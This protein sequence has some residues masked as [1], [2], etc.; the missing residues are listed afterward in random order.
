MNH[1]IIYGFKCI[2]YEDFLYKYLIDYIFKFS[3]ILNDKWGKGKGKA[4]L[5][6]SRGG[7]YGCETSRLSHFLDNQ[8]THGGE[9]VSL[10][11]RPS[12]TP[13][14]IPGTHFCQRLSRC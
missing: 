1:D 7:P 4:I 10:M 3:A 13:R 14:K 12:F 6:R 8:L 2:Y 9:V 5:I 11:R